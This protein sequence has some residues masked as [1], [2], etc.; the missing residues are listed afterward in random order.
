MATRGLGPL[1]WGL[2]HTP[3]HLVLVVESDLSESLQC[4]CVCVYVCAWVL[5][6]KSKGRIIA[7]SQGECQR[8]KTLSSLRTAFSLFLFLNLFAFP[9]CSFCS[10][11]LLKY[12]K[13]LNIFKTRLN[14]LRSTT[15]CFQMQNQE[16]RIQEFLKCFNVVMSGC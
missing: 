3:W 15:T 14:Y 6:V 1:L 12:Y 7:F 9:V 5:E 13:N 8:E 10:I 16:S 11:S 2:S 4:V